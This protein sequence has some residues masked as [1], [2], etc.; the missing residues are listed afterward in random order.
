MAHKNCK[1][2]IMSVT[3]KQFLQ[4][5]LLVLVLN[6][7]WKQNYLTKKLINYDTVKISSTKIENF[8]QSL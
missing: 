1:K 6:I 8:G 4:K 5:N 2:D 3:N 7:N